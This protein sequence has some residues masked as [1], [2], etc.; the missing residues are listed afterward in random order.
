MVFDNTRH[1]TV[2]QMIMQDRYLH[3]YVPCVKSIEDLPIQYQFLVK[4]T[5]RDNK[6][7]ESSGINHKV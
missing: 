1:S 3:S 4:A 2:V 7:Q 6:I 5:N